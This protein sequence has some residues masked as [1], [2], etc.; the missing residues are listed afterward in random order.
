MSFLRAFLVKRLHAPAWGHTPDWHH[1]FSTAQL[2][3]WYE[4]TLESR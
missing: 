1:D 4:Q 3:R 2:W